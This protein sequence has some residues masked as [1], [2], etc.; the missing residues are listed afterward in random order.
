MTYIVEKQKKTG[1][2]KAPVSPSEVSKLVADA[3]PASV[4]PLEQEFD[5][6]A[7]EQLDLRRDKDEREVMTCFVEPSV[8]AIADLEATGK[9]GADKVTKKEENQRYSN[10]QTLLKLFQ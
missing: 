1:G 10:F 5:D 8:L 4:N 7:G 3:L 9:N 6:D 2:G